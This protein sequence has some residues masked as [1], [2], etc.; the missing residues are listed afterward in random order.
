[1]VVAYDYTVLAGTQGAAQP[2]EAGPPVRAC[3]AAAPA[4]RPVR[5]RRRRPAGRHGWARRQRSRRADLRAIREAQRARAAHRNRLRPVLRRQRRPARLL[6]RGDRHARREDRHGRPGDDRGRRPRRLPPGGGR[7]GRRAG[8]ERR[9]RPPGRGR[10]RRPAATAKRY[11]AYFQ[12]RGRG[13]D[14][15]PTSAS[16]A[17]PSR[18]TGCASTTSVQSSR[19]W[20]TRAPCS[21]CAR[22]SGVGIVTALDPHRGP[23]VRSHRQQSRSI[24][25]GA[26]DSDA[27]DKAARFMQLC[28]AFDLPIVSL[29]RHAGLHGRAGS[30]E[31]R[32]RAPCLPHVRDRGEPR[33]SRISPSS[34][35][36]ATGS[37]R[38]PWPAAGSTRSASPSP[39]RPASSAAWASKA[40]CGSASA[41]SSRRSRTRRSA[42]SS[43]A[44][45][46]P[47]SYEIGKATNIASVLE[48]DQVIDP[49]ETR[50]WIIRGLDS[51]PAP[52]AARRRKRPFVDTW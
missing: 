7:A 40:P 24:S 13:L 11:L 46:W 35:A 25:A 3:R 44:R 52:R 26:I 43:S 5:R 8:A 49:V 20:R 29:T 37:A 16:C 32:A 6:R 33:R 22:P 19:R 21:S 51:C 10:N 36:R 38:R 30:G 31:D 27:A 14:A 1:M 9:H 47:N 41:R 23:A 18:K 12:G 50:R 39:G 4:G 34:C 42:T 45:W 2:Q 15:R 28:D 48:I 17:A